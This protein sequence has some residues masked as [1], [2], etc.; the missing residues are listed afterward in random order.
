VDYTTTMKRQR[1]SR[2][3]V[4]AHAL[5]PSACLWLV[6]MPCGLW[7]LASPMAIYQWSNQGYIVANQA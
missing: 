3:I 2:D 4:L 1:G 5:Q 7:M 6:A